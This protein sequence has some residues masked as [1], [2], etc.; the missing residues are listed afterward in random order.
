M[1]ALLLNFYFG[2]FYFIFLNTTLPCLVF[3]WYTFYCLFY[4]FTFQILYPY[5]VS[6]P[7]TPY[8]IRPPPCCCEGAHRFYAYSYLTVSTFVLGI[9]QNELNMFLMSMRNKDL[10]GIQNLYWTKG[11]E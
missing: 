6:P 5:W 1:P 7:D 10:W 3:F 11:H 9:F 8:P 2:R 4:L